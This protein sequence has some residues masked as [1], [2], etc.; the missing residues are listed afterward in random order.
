MA[1][2]GL[3]PEEEFAVYS[4]SMMECAKNVAVSARLGQPVCSALLM[5]RG[6]IL[7]MHEASLDGEAIYLSILCNKL[8]GGIQG[9]INIIIDRLGKSLLGDGHKE[10]A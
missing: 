6:R 4:L 9:L 5:E 2:A 10:S 7:I 8:P 3:L 1:E